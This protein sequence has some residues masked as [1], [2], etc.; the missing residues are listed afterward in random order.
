MTIEADLKEIRNLLST[1]NKKMDV[2]IGDKESLQYMT[3]AEK[4]LKEFL[5]QE[6]DIYTAQ[7]IKARVKHS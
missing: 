7:D 3:L 4:S 1:L 5:E 6:P 2:L